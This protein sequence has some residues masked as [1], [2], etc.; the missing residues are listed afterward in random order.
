MKR[1]VVL[2]SALLL[3]VSA[4]TAC[5]KE[6]KTV[7]L[8]NDD[9]KAA[10]SIG[11]MTAQSME[12]QVPNFNVDS[13]VAG[14]KDAYAKKAGQINEEEM[15]KALTAFEAKVRKEATERQEKAAAEAV[16][17][18][19]TYLAEN[20]KKAG[21]KTTASGLQYE[22]IKEGTGAKPV[23]TDTVKVHYEGKLVDGTVFD[24]SIKRGEPVSFPLNQV[25]AGWTE[26]LQLM[27]VGSKYR[28]VIPA[29]LAYG[30]QGGGQI[31]PNSVL[32]FEVELL[33]ITK[34]Q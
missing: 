7:K 20:A 31:P 25:I 23:A 15:K 22:V 3:L 8:D 16:T 21:V 32:T 26:G 4:I 14:F 27:T 30:E 18:G 12:K 11:Y 1:Q 19:A 29:N 33:E 13:Y 34:A 10:Y 2:G 6:E 9:A 28:F 5:N 24:S 17:K